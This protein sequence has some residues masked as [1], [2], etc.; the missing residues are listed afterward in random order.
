MRALTFERS[1][2]RAGEKAATKA[3]KQQVANDDT[4]APAS[5]SA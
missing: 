5:Q 4:T 3:G 1:N 2:A